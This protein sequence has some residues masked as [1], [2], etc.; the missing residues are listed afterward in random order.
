MVQASAMPGPGVW[1]ELLIL[2]ALLFCSAFISGAEVAYFSLSPADLEKLSDKKGKS[3]SSV[4]KL[5]ANP[6]R[7]LSTILVTNN[8]LNIA[9]I[10]LAAFITPELFNLNNNPV[11][12][13]IIEAIAITFILL[14]FGEI[15]PK[16][17]ASLYQ[18][19]FVI[20][21]AR[22]LTFCQKIFR[23]ITSLLVLSSFFMKKR[24]GIHS[25][26][27]SM[28]DLSD[29]L[30]L[31]S[32]EIK[33]DKEILRGIVRFGNTNVSS[34]MCPRIDVM[35]LDMDESYHNILPKV[36][37]SGFSR[38]PVYSGSF[39]NIK[40][41]LF[42]K[43]L[44]GRLDKDDHFR[45]QALIKPAY[46][47]PETKKISDL[48]KD[49]QSKKIHMAIVVDEYGGTSGLVTLEDILEEIVGDIIDET[50]EETPLFKSLGPGCWIF[51]GK[52]LIN[53]F[54]RITESEEE[55][56]EDLKGDSETLAGLLLETLG[57]IPEKGRVVSIG[58][59]EF[60]IESVDKRRIREIRVSR[61][62]E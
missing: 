39:D 34:V 4:L 30:D 15:I 58:D 3:A 8:T 16:I 23:P 57:E 49:F 44:I 55:P 60:T 48:L 20:A 28:D 54:Y 38:I 6:E 36:I 1:G 46:F 37:D 12:A 25:K 52:V 29:A 24:T 51:E 33:E 22:P 19:R 35:A 5:L 45:W 13:F 50:D 43:D 47:V 21:M 40:G 56:F 7:L 10:I 14:L 59:F 2:I 18:F 41:L 53:D 62:E 11:L 32:A 61:I 9:I 31:T 17:Y 27:I 42:V 26:N